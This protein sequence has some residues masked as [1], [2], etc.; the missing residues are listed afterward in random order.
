M[1]IFRIAMLAAAIA[2]TVVYAQVPAQQTFRAGV[3]YV[4]ID[5]VV[6][7]R[8]GNFVRNLTKSDFQVLE[9]GKPQAISVFSIVDI[10]TDNAAG[11]LA[12]HSEDP[13]APPSDGPRGR[14][15][16]MVLDDLHTPPLRTPL[17]RRAARLFIE[18]HMGANDVAALVLTSGRTNGSQEL[19]GDKQIL[20]RAVDR[21]TGQKLRPFENPPDAERGFNARI[22]MSSLRDV[23]ARMGELHGRRKA[24]LFISEGIDYD[25][26]DVF[27]ARDAS[28]VRDEVKAAISAATRSNVSIYSVDP[29]GLTSLVDEDIE[30]GESSPLIGPGSSSERL[31]LAQDSLRILSDMTGGLAAV[32]SNDFAGIFD[33]IVR[34]NSTYYLLGFN[35][36]NDKRD[37]RFRKLDVR[38]ARDG[39]M[40]RARKGYVLPRE[41]RR[42]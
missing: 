24:L 16:V 28:I 42:R 39:V 27:E 5:A 32:N 15:Y 36:A 14:L 40:V 26:Y 7:D 1:R 17:V 20:L 38:V 4:E 13:D 35:P 10:P 21:F 37:G 19:T 2:G 22:A 29:R 33:R 3:D 34:D 25:I 31:R 41:E 30:R 9:D 23:A 6:T 12:A 18:R 8:Q 11:R